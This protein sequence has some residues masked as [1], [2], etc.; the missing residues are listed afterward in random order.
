MSKKKLGLPLIVAGGLIGLLSTIVPH[1]FQVIGMVVALV[2]ATI[3]IILLATDA[4]SASSTETSEAPAKTTASSEPDDLT[5]IEGVGP[6]LQEILYAA[7]VTTYAS[8]A[9]SSAETLTEKIKSGGFKA[10]FKADSWAEQAKLA[11]EGKWS[12]LETLQDSL[13]GGRKA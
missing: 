2:I 9:A 5:K 6:K 1:D 3:G 4:D 7:G 13:V 10:P 8:L 12:E 11:A